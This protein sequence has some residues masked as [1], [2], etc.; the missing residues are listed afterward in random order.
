MDY[1]HE[2]KNVIPSSYYNVLYKDKKGNDILNVFVLDTNLFES[3][4]KDCAEQK[5][6]Q[7]VI[8]QQIEWFYRTLNKSNSKYNIVIGHIPYKAIGH[9]SKDFYIYNKNLQP[10]FDIIKEANKERKKVQAYFCA[11]EHDQQVLYDRTNNLHLII[12]GSGGTALD[13][14]FGFNESDPDNKENHIKIM[15]KL[16]EENLDFEMA[17]SNFGFANLKISKSTGLEIGIIDVKTDL[18]YTIPKYNLN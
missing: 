17:N 1:K 13:Q 12:I 2:N 8:D 7:E 11:D 18:I 6:P 15:N 10:I 3:S 4:P 9:K 5:Y 16:K 14:I